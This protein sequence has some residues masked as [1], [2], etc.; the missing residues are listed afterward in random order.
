MVG[1]RK[2]VGRSVTGAPYAMSSAE[3]WVFSDF[4]SLLG[5]SPACV[6]RLDNMH[7]RGCLHGVNAQ[8]HTYQSTH[9]HTYIIPIIFK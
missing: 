8:A 1:R 6:C 9:A 4:C 7:T 2:R 5:V 3:L